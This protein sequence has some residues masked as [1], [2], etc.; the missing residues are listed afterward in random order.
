MTNK[1]VALVTG[2]SSG[3][4]EASAN[5]LLAAGYTVYGTSRR[6]SQAGKHPFP[7]LALDVTDDAS[8]E[9][10]IDELLR[11][12][13]RIDILVNNAGF[14]V[15]PAAAEESS[16]E[17]AKSIF[18][19]NFLGIVRLTRAVVPHMRRQGCGRIINIG[20][21]LG[22]IPLPY[23]A[24]YA[25][26]KHAVEGYSGALDHEL[27]TQGIR[28]SVIEPA[29]IKTQF[30]VNN[31]E[32]DAKLGEYEMI[33]AK[34][35]KVVSKAMAEAESPEVVAEV[36]VKAAKTSHPTLRY[37]AGKLAGK[38]NFLLRFAP[39]KFLDKVVR[40]SLQLDTKE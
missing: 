6:G 29:Y 15:A 16:I 40:N 8:V 34:L 35:T 33:R 5:Q 13:G 11:R 23:V 32:P 26:S 27:R 10:A 17:Q 18:D 14:G 25:A 24:L 38:L 36:V 7:L 2:A 19:T 4:G 20:S 37:T 1:R 12:E 3:I 21:I 28:V 31:I 22:V 39:A 30:E 9:A